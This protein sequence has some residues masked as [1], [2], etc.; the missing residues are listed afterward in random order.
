[1]SPLYPGRRRGEGRAETQWGF[2]ILLLLSLL[3]PFSA[4]VSILRSVDIP[5]GYEPPSNAALAGDLNSIPT[6]A[7]ERLGQ[8]DGLGNG[9]WLHHSRAN[10]R[11]D[12]DLAA[13]EET[14]ETIARLLWR[15][16][17]RLADDIE[18]AKVPAGLEISHRAAVRRA[19]RS[20]ED[21]YRQVNA[22]FTLGPRLSCQ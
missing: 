14:R 9:Q 5:G 1:M 13:V 8:D 7:W 20:Y 4:V 10:T 21:F 22:T 3:S 19:I 17:S 12:S 2:R 11:W 6:F 16:L 15:G 18:G